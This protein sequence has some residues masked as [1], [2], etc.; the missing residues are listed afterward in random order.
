MKLSVEQTNSWT[1]E[2]RITNNGQY[3]KYDCTNI[4]NEPTA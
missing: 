1:L 2:D 4:S 3:A